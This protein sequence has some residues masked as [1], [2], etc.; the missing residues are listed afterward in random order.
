MSV[1]RQREF[2]TS[3]ALENAMK[4]FWKHGYLGA[5]LAELT[6]AMGIS[7]PSMY[8]TYGNKEKLFVQA[9]DYYIEHFASPHGEHLH[10]EKPLKQRLR[11]FIFSILKSQ[12][13][14]QN[15]KGCLVSLSV[16]TNS[17]V[18]RRVFIQLFMR[19]NG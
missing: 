14:N 3:E 11:S 4:V 2:C 19:R 13:D 16:A 8:G 15:P 1:G 6:E 12:C 9:V 18:P 17:K 5:S 7:K 10:G